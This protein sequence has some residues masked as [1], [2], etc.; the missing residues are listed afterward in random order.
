M[1]ETHKQLAGFKELRNA[2]VDLLP[3]GPFDEYSLIEKKDCKMLCFSLIFSFN[4][5]RPSTTPN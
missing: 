5:K 1:L 2:S 4:L 3:A